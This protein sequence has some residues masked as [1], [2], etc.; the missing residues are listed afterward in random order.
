MLKTL[1]ALRHPPG[2]NHAK[3]VSFLLSGETTRLEKATGFSFACGQDG[4]F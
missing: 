4:P 2:A 3:I 1:W